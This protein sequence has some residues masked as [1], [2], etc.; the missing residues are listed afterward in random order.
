[1]PRSSRLR[2]ISESCGRS[3][4]RPRLR[5]PRRVGV[6]S[7][8]QSRDVCRSFAFIRGMTH[9]ILIAP[10]TPL[11]NDK[12]AVAGATHHL[13]GATV[14]NPE[15]ARR[16]GEEAVSA[17]L[18]TRW[19]KKPVVIHA[20]QFTGPSRGIW[21]ICGQRIDRLLGAMPMRPYRRCSFITPRLPRRHAPRRRR[22]FTQPLTPRL[23]IRLFTYALLVHVFGSLRNY[24]GLRTGTRHV[25]KSTASHSI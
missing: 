22:P 1:M 17:G 4:A 21:S 23:R 13:G 19:R 8:L 9:T 7:C 11:R 24:R 10:V 6:G 5:G 3:S 2:A 12:I 20:I 15:Y 18:A 14:F 16:I 25:R